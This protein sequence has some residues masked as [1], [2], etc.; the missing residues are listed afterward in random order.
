MDTKDIKGPSQG[1]IFDLTKQAGEFWVTAGVCQNKGPK[2]G[3]RSK[4]SENMSMGSALRLTNTTDGVLQFMGSDGRNSLGVLRS[5]ICLAGKSIRFRKWPSL[6]ISVPSHW[7]CWSL[8][9]SKILRIQIVAKG[10]D[11]KSGVIIKCKEKICVAGDYDLGA[12]NE[13]TKEY[14]DENNKKESD[15]T[16][17]DLKWIYLNKNRIAGN[18]SILCCA[19]SQ[20]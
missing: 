19:P 1:K 20:C 5:F 14:P 6:Q 8:A 15:C 17:D 7:K 12:F 13:C 11:G 16:D 4:G 2:H 3:L 10:G 9:T 18:A